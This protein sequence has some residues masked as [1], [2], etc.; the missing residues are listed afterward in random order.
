LAN[1]LIP[2]HSLDKLPPKL[3]HTFDFRAH[4]MD[5]ATITKSYRM[6]MTV[7]DL[8]N[9]LDLP[10]E[11]YPY[12]FVQIGGVHIPW[13][14]WHLTRPLPGAYVLIAVVPKGGVG[15][16]IAGV[17]LIAA[18]FIINGM[19]FGALTPVLGGMVSMGLGLILGGAA[20]LL[21][22]P[23][24]PNI[25]NSRSVGEESSQTY[26]LTGASNKIMP[27]GPV[28]KLY[29][30]HKY[31]P[32][33]A[34]T[35][36]NMW[37]ANN[38]DYFII[39]DLGLGK[40]DTKN[41]YISI[42]ETS[43]D[44]FQS[45]EKNF[46]YAP[47]EQFKLYNKDVSTENFQYKIENGANVIRNTLPA[48]QEIQVDLA[49]PQGLFSIDS[50][51]NTVNESV[52]FSVEY[53]DAA[54]VWHGYGEAPFSDL[55]VTA[56]TLNPKQDISVNYNYSYD[57]SYQYTY[58]TFGWFN[59]LTVGTA[60]GYGTD[61][62]IKEGTTRLSA[63]RMPPDNSKIFIGGIQYKVI[64]NDGLTFLIDRPIVANVL[65]AMDRPGSGGIFG[66]GAD[67]NRTHN[68]YFISTGIITFTANKQNPIYMTV[69]MSGL[70]AAQY[71][72]RITK[73]STTGSG[74]FKH[75]NTMYLAQIKSIKLTTPINCPIPHTYLEV[76][77][78]AND[79]LSGNLTN[80]SVITTSIL[81]V[82]NGTAWVEEPTKNP[83]WIFCDIL[84]GDINP[85]KI[86]RSKL[87][88]ESIYAWAQECDRLRTFDM[89]IDGDAGNIVEKTAQCSFIMDY[90]TTIQ[91]LLAQ[92]CS[93]GRATFSIIGGKYGVIQDKERTTPIQVFTPR[94]YSNF[95]STRTYKQM[96]HGIK[97]KFVDPESNWNIAEK[98][99]Y[100]TEDGYN[101]NNSTIF[102]EMDT[103][104][105]N[106]PSFAWR[107]GRY[108][109]AQAKLRQERMSINVDFE[110]L[111]CV[112]GDLV[113]L[114]SDVMEVGGYPVR[115][116]RVSG[117]Q[118]FLDAPIDNPGGALMYEV[119]Q[120]NGIVSKGNITSIA[121]DGYSVFIPN[122]AGMTAGDLFIFGQANKTAIDCIVE[123]I[124]PGPDL[125]ANITLLEYAPAIFDADLLP[126][127][128]YDSQ[129]ITSVIGG[130]PPKIDTA[131]L[132]EEIIH[133]NRDAFSKININLAVPPGTVWATTSVYL[134]NSF[135][136]FVYIESIPGQALQY[137]YQVPASD[138][139]KNIAAGVKKEFKFILVGNNG[140]HIEVSDADIYSITL[141][142]DIQPP[143]APTAI[144]L[145]LQQDTLMINW[146]LPEG[147]NDLG[148]FILKYT[149]VE[150]QTISW[151][152]M[153]PFIAD[154]PWDANSIK[155]SFR[156]GTYAIRTRDTSGNVS[157]T[158]IR[159]L[160]S[161]PDVIYQSPVDSI[162]PE[163]VFWPDT[164]DNVV[165]VSNELQLFQQSPN[166]TVE[167]GYYYFNDT[168]DVGE[169]FTMHIASYITG[170]GLKL[171]V[172]MNHPTWD[173]LANLVAMN[174]VKE[175]EAQFY[176]Q[177]RMSPTSF[178][179]SAWP[180][181]DV[182]D[183][184]AQGVVRWT[185]WKTIF[186]GDATGRIFQ[187]RILLLRTP[188]LTDITPVV[189][190]G[191]FDITIELATR[192]FEDLVIIG[193]RRI[194]FDP[195]FWATPSLT[196]T[197]QD[198]LQGDYYKVRN[199]SGTG[200]DLDFFDL[201]GTPVTRTADVSAYGKGRRFTRMLG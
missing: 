8:V 83:A 121:S 54:L 112:Q 18:A 123:S 122:S 53:R 12:L 24:K 127:P 77:I 19:S 154:I 64:S 109:L 13:N 165:V 114:T 195:Q 37:V 4:P 120:Q 15:K 52:T 76:K 59:E 62:Y 99:V 116:V 150:V 91:Q 183:P 152:E 147:V 93:S 159:A 35:P 133:E 26:S 129:E 42:G 70:P 169:V 192:S 75:E 128:P 131:I 161:A 153:S 132:N 141:A 71:P 201:N 187:F 65:I 163:S 67:S 180:T 86:P 143:T 162:V 44:Q 107:L 158:D 79:Q 189:K 49:F 92:V 179:M 1:E 28:M 157:T 46:V 104:G 72:V 113:R 145:N 101:E 41:T 43:I 130:T 94:N 142:G 118:L 10:N 87:H 51:G 181:L 2:I 108:F 69:I 63:N 148:G 111:V 74:G 3:D 200:F 30:T 164:K 176:L 166:N 167:R 134:K 80:V 98:I 66:G 199:K 151:N 7:L 89:E 11:M 21:F 126:I 155:V 22:P 193:T 20:E 100:N 177:Y 57:V 85:R 81:S 188:D 78:K 25:S 197:A 119:R 124:V 138:N 190:S 33:I 61:Y 171:G 140:N 45:V 58:L 55:G 9:E 182:I 95:S 5:S 6:G 29:G 50:N 56:D 191:R 36:Y 136:A 14:K 178:F 40:I 184:I 90:D 105:C 106:T 38:Q 168:L 174:N 17:V 146:P 117:S 16:I 96:P 110:N 47:S 149:P 39:F 194:V 196:I 27:F 139:F 144:S 32:N 68:T 185:D 160:A 82:W 23:P 172:F 135:G 186:T 48:T 198:L 88:I 156:P 31:Y 137:Y 97:V 60:T 175:N 102:E 84:C 103:F 173:P 170:Y 125:T 115:I 34:A 73:I